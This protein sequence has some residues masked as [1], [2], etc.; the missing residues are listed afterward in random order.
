V[1]E[2]EKETGLSW[3]IQTED[4]RDVNEKARKVQ[5]VIRDRLSNIALDLLN[6]TS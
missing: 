5:L 1:K 3:E 2:L 6:G 4:L